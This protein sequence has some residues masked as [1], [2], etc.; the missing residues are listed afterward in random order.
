MGLS[1]FEPGRKILD[2]P[3]DVVQLADYLDTNRFS[4][5]R[6][7]GG[8]SD[9]QHALTRFQTVL[10]LAALPLARGQWTRWARKA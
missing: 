3:K 4:V 9:A 5:E 6:V 8:G 7:S 1:D 2:W 10:R